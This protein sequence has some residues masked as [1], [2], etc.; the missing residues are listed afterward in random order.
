MF[1][2]RKLVNSLPLYLPDRPRRSPRCLSQR[3]EHRRTRQL[4]PRKINLL[5]GT[6][7]RQRLERMLNLPREARASKRQRYPQNVQQEKLRLCAIGNRYTSYTA[8]ES[9]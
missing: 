2:G 9:R 1:Y 6:R 3:R 5:V 4:N 8:E 7:R